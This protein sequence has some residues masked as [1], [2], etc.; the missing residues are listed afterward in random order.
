[1]EMVVEEHQAC[2]FRVEGGRE[3]R[4]EERKKGFS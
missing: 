4:K 2:F 1:M 3:E